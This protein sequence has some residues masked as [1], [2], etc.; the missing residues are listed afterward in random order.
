MEERMMCLDIPQMDVFTED[1]SSVFSVIEDAARKENGLLELR[2]SWEILFSAYDD[3]PRE[4]PDIPEVAN[5]IRKSVSAGVPWLYLLR[6]EKEPACSLTLFVIICCGEISEDPPGVYIDREQF[7]QFVD[8]NFAN[9]E[10][11]VSRYD[12][13][14][15][16][17][18][19]T[20]NDAVE[21]ILETLFGK[22]DDDGAEEEYGQA[23]GSMDEADRAA[24]RNK[25][26]AEAIRRLTALEGMYL[27]NPNIKKY[28]SEGRLYYSYL[29]GGGYI[30]SIDTISYDKRYEE[31]VKKFEA[32]TSALV[33]HAVEHRNTLSLFFVSPSIS[34]WE[35]EQPQKEGVLAQV[36]D[37]DTGESRQG[38]IKLDVLQGAF[39][40]R[41]SRVYSDPGTDRSPDEGLDPQ[42]VEI[43]RRLNILK[44]QGLT[45]DLDVIDL[46]QRRREICLSRLEMVF[47]YPVGVILRSSQAEKY[48]KL[49]VQMKEQFSLTPYFAMVTNLDEFRVMAVLFLS[50]DPDDW[51]EERDALGDKEPYAVVLDF[52]HMSLDVK[53]I[54]YTFC[55]G[56]PVYLPD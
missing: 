1:Y 23:S 3:D 13:P 41:D 43:I 12:M 54:E 4:T 14:E 46:Y 42:D 31:I 34:Q 44:K 20:A 56:G 7:R 30:G 28:F 37:L 21:C 10:A 49:I 52:E 19:Q 25:Q 38:Y 9:L 27:L 2:S 40:R 55:N 5:W 35:R 47:G 18:G 26:T 48:E 8:Q 33:Y 6:Q 45:S 24:L 51:E 29:T 16:L 39:Y 15:D 32:E 36:F 22:R 50:P 17:V 11:F 53:R